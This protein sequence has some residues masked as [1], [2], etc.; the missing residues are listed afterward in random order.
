MIV[1]LNNCMR[2]CLLLCI[3]AF[4]CTVKM[5]NN[6][7]GQEFS[8]KTDF[9]VLN[10]RQ[11]ITKTSEI[12]EGPDGFKTIKSSEQSETGFAIEVVNLKK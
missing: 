8:V 5:K 10:Q 3:F 4:G 6:P 9:S 12:V 11:V 2:I 7:T 1:P